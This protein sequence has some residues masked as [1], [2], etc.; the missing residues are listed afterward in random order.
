MT[1]SPDHLLYNRIIREQF[2]GELTIKP[3]GGVRGLTQFVQ[4]Y[5]SGYEKGKE[6]PHLVIRD[7]DFLDQDVDNYQLSSDVQLLKV[8]RNEPIYAVHRTCIENYF[9]DANLLHKYLKPRTQSQTG[10]TLTLENMAHLIEQSGVEISDYQAVRWALAKLQPQGGW[11]NIPHSLGRKFSSGA[12]PASLD[13]A[14]C[15]REAASLQ[16]AFA[17]S[18]D[19]IATTDLR[20]TA[21]QFR[22]QFHAA[23]LQTRLIWFHGKDWFTR[24]RMN[25]NSFCH[26]HG[27]TVKFEKKNFNE[28]AVTAVNAH[29]HPDLLELII[30]VSSKSVMR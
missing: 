14:D 24:L 22:D 25:I 5:L 2:A 10:K 28:W 1:S 15:L 27:I 26:Q 29:D 7:R 4:G 20:R 17:Q 3:F 12:L 19:K 6:P 16:A 11:P 23:D 13:Y 21:N 18:T 30:L 8:H 9:L